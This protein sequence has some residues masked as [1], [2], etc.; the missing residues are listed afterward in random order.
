MTTK[1]K[2]LTSIAGLGDPDR[3]KLDAKYVRLSASM[4]AEVDFRGKKRSTESIAAAVAEEKRK[5][6]YDEKPIGF[7]T[8]WS[9]RSGDEAV[10]DSEL[11][12][13]WA[14][15]GI[16]IILPTEKRAA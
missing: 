5:D 1:I 2:L 11:A 14:D 15:S 3:A 16:C 9:F 4:Q 13:K 10:I 8:D 7:K 6:R 12:K